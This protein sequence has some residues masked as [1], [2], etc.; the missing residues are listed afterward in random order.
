MKKVTVAILVVG[1]SFVLSVSTSFAKKAK[2]EEGAG[3]S[4][5]ISGSVIFKG[6][7]LRSDFCANRF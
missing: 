1:I 3:G 6:D 4:G 2:Y 7:V 5:S